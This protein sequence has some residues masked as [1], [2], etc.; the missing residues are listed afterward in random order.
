LTEIC[1]PNDPILIKIIREIPLS[2]LIH[3]LE[4]VFF[5]YRLKYPDRYDPSAFKQY[6]EKIDFS[7]NPIDSQLIIENGFLVFILILKISKLEGFEKDEKFNLISDLKRSIAMKSK[8]ILS[9]TI[10]REFKSLAKGFMNTGKSYL[11][12]FAKQVKKKI[13]NFIFFIDSF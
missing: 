3:Y 2:V 9:K 6:K 12:V 8:G 7:K 5:V 11:N 13:R 1:L 10:F 4:H